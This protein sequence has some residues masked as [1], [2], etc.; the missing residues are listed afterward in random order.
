[1]PI[2]MPAIF[3]K[4]VSSLASVLTQRCVRIKFPGSM[5]VLA[6]SNK[7]YKIYADHLL[8]YHGNDV[9]KLPNISLR[10]ASGKLQVGEIRMGRTYLLKGLKGEREVLIDDPREYWKVRE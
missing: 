6:P 5:N 1:M 2:S 3:N 10:D 9:D 8:S 7:I 4:M